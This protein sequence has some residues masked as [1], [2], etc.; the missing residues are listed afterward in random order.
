ME[1]DHILIA[2]ADLG[3]AGREFEVRHGLASVEGGRHPGWGTANRIVPLGDSYLELVAVVD[4]IRAAES[5]F[6]RWVASAASSAAPPLG[7]AVRTSELDGVARRLGLPV[8]IGSR[9]IPGGGQLRW[10]TVGIE[11]AAADPSLPFFIE[12]AAG[13]YLPGQGAI[14]HPSGAAK[15]SRLVIDGDPGRLASW[16][17]DHQLPIEVR[18]GMPALGAIHISSGAGAIVI[19]LAES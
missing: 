13:T 3:A 17:G 10:R 12:W 6:G 14:G 7:W 4:A 1:L 16:L 9:S 15:I 2:V 19:G 11:Q 8:Q 18:S 5:V